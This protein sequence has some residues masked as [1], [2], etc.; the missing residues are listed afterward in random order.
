LLKKV[1][2]ATP[3]SP[4]QVVSFRQLFMSLVVSQDASIRLLIEGVNIT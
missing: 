3:L 1:A 4:K 2:V